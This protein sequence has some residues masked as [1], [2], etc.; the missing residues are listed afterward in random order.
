ML[1]HA[2]D[3]RPEAMVA[4]PGVVG[5]PATPLCPAMDEV[6]NGDIVWSH[7]FIVLAMEDG[8]LVDAAAPG[9]VETEAVIIRLVGARVSGGA[10]GPIDAGGG[11]NT[12]ANAAPAV[13]A[14]VASAGRGG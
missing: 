5:V 10:F 7:G 3:E 8:W 9:A 14:A 13:A 6:E 12:A 1:F 4:S 2:A 11:L